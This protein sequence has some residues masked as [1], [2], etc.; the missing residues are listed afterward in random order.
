VGLG[1]AMSSRGYRNSKAGL[2]CS[3]VGLALS[4]ALVVVG[5]AL[6]SS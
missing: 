6:F 3:I 4:V 1:L 5:V 2:I